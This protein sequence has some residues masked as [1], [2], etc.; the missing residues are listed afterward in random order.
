MLAL[1]I[2]CASPNRLAGSLVYFGAVGQIICSVEKGLLLAFLSIIFIQYALK[3]L[4]ATFRI[5][6]MMNEQ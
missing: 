1:F 4:G 5:T 3:R 2:L 6:D